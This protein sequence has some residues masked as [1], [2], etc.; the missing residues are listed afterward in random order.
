MSLIVGCDGV[1]EKREVKVAV[2]VAVLVI[3]EKGEV[4]VFVRFI[5]GEGVIVFVIVG[6]FGVKVPVTVSVIEGVTVLV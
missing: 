5:V 1:G 3:K 2:G 6:V 4:G